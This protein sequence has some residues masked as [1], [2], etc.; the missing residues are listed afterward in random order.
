MDKVSH[1]TLVADYKEVFRDSRNEF[2]DFLSHVFMQLNETKFFGIIDQILSSD[3]LTD[4]ELYTTLQKKISQA[5]F[6]PIGNLR[7]ALRSLRCL[8]HDLSHQVSQ[9]LGEGAGVEGYVEIGYPGRMVRPIKSKVSLKG[10]VT[11]IND[12][13]RLSDYIQSGFP[14]PY[15]QFL[16][17]KNY[18]PISEKS[19]PSESVDLVTCFIGLHHAPEEKIDQFVA[20]IKRILRPG[21][22][23]ILMDHDAL[24]EKLQKLLRVV[25]SVFNAATGVS[26]K[27]E[28][29]EVRD[30]KP[31][32]HWIGKVEACGLKMHKTPLMRK[33]DAT[34]NSTLLF[35]KEP[36][37]LEELNVAL[38]HDNKAQIETFQTSLEWHIVRVSEYFAQFV[39]EKPIYHFPFFQEIRSS[40]KVFID[41]WNA[42]RKYGSFSEVL[43][44]G[45]TL[46]NLFLLVMLT[47]EFGIKGILLSPLK[48]IRRTKVLSNPSWARK[49]YAQGANYYAKFIRHTPF[50]SYSYMRDIKQFWNEFTLFRKDGLDDLVLGIILTIENLVKAAIS[51]FIRMVS[52]SS[53]MKENETITLIVKRAHLEDVKIIEGTNV[54]EYQGIRLPRYIPFKEA[55]YRLTKEGVETVSIAGQTHIQIDRRIRI[56]EKLTL[57]EG[58]KLL[59]RQKLP[60]NEKE[61]L[62]ILDSDVSHLRELFAETSLE[63]IEYMHD[64]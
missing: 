37:S 53:S 28:K 2:K 42:A 29:E 22:A 38:R 51:F 8:K 12:K 25:H 26:W 14:R 5:K 41:S 7:A 55:L 62:A 57:P 19:I 47:I 33:G 35:K 31:L 4:E 20:S 58:T 34:L 32:S 6:G 61:E 17:L 56:G 9:L 30:F 45:D 64:F 24:D 54:G 16:E 43:F 18:E 15:K 13:E 21:G 27:E 1:T 40:W 49:E 52:Q 46:M 39:K 48:L 60:G 3:H 59:Y 44:S 36:T 23:F 50:Y 11:V 63:E 10:K